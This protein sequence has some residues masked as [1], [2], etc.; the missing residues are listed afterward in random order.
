MF[1]KIR[2]HRYFPHFFGLIVLLLVILLFFL[3]SGRAY[4]GVK[5]IDIHEHIQSLEKAHEL[6]NVM[7]RIG[8]EKTVLL[9]SPWQTLTLNGSKS[10]TR[11]EENMDEI[12]KIAETYPES[13]VPL[14][15]VSPMDSNALE[16]FRSCHERGGKGLKLYNGHSYYYDIFKTALDSTRMKPIYAYAER[17]NLPILYHINLKKYGDELENIL[18]E[19]PDLVI[20]VPHYMVSSIE[21]DEVK[22]MFDTYPNLYT[23]IS[24][25]SPQFFAAGF[26]R[27]S[28]NIEKYRDFFREYP[29][30]ILFGTDMVLT[31]IE[32]KDEE[33]MKATL[34]CYRDLLEKKKFTCEPVKNYY[35]DEMEKNRSMAEDC[36]TQDSKFC[37]SKNEKLKSYTRWYE[38]VKVLN[39]LNLNAGIL[40]KVY[41]ENPERWLGANEG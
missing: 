19:F 10:F 39:G 23:D 3:L 28:R 16:I 36:L 38:E 22:R 35:K 26:R 25:G 9:P 18:K 17:N 20:N 8:I 34:Q 30:R 5:V 31:D 24:F 14:C 37:K 6:K 15:T 21:I 29:D 12:L 27:I 2:Q 7:D 41:S 4:S 11:H 32:T 1:K 13:F 40:K 33:F